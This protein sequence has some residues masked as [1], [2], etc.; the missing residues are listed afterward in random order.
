VRANKLQEAWQAEDGTKF[1]VRLFSLFSLFLSLNSLAWQV[2]CL[3]NAAA[4]MHIE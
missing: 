3:F 4:V 1:K 2:V